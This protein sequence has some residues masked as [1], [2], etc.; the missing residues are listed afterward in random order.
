MRSLKRN[1][2]KIYFR[3]YEGE[4]EII[5]EYGNETGS[6]YPIYGELKSAMICVS[7]NIGSAEVE[8]FGT[9]EDYDRTMTIGD[10]SIGSE[11][12][13]VFEITENTVLWV[14]GA[15]TEGPWNYIVKLVAPWKNSISF[16]IKRVK[17]S[18][19]KETQQKIEDAL[20]MKEAT[21]PNGN[22]DVS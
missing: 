22:Q 7:P 20:K 4:E 8:Q 19:Y 1:Q 13:A 17:V 15:D 18:V 21:T 11:D 9:M 14:D 5:D 10:T 2:Q 6:Y 16:A 3:I 12:P